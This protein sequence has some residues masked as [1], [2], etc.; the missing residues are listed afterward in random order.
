MHLIKNWDEVAVTEQR[1]HALRIF[2]TVIAAVQP[3]QALHRKL[4]RQA[5]LLTVGQRT[6]DLDQFKNIFVVGIGKAALDAA[7]FLEEVLGDRLSSGIVLDTR[8]G[9]LQRLVSLAGTHPL[10]TEVNVR[11]TERICAAVSAAQADDLV[12]VIVS[13]GGSALLCQP[14]DLTC[15]EVSRITGALITSG[16]AI[17]EINTVRKHISEVQGGQLARLAYPAAMV[18]LIFCDIPSEDMSLVA[19]GPT[20]LDRSTV[21]D[22]EKILTKYDVIKTCRLEGCTLRETPKSAKLFAKVHNELIVNGAEAARS[23]AQEA[24]RLG[25]ESP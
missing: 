9:P 20:F 15:E 12:L 25:Y 23:M 8:T 2:E 3:G 22:A 19:S 18:G 11:A 24:E 13:G 17:E 10:P 6:Y 1:Q 21:Q 7:A 4:S 16:A 5:N 14:Y